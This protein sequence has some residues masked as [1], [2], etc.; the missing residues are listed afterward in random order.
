MYSEIIQP[1]CI[2]KCIQFCKQNFNSNVNY[3]L[4]SIVSLATVIQLK[5]KITCQSFS[6]FK[7]ECTLM[8]CHT[9]FFPIIFKI[10]LVGITL[11]NILIH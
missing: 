3:I 2:L 10:F 8:I 11:L 1:S 4:N 5:A 7:H 6:A 9:E